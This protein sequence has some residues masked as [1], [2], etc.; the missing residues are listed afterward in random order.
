MQTQIAPIE[1][2]LVDNNGVIIG[3]SEKMLV[4]RRGLLHLAFSLMIT[5]QGH[6]GTEF[7]LQRR[8][9]HKYHSGGLWTNTCCSHPLKHE[10][11]ADAAKRRVNDELGVTAPLDIR[12]VAK[13][14]YNHQLENGLYEN[15]YNHLLLADVEDIK[16]NGNP[17]EVM[18]IRWWCGNEI[19][20]ALLSSPERF[21]AWFSE[22][23]ANVYHQDIS[24]LS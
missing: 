10:S 11:I 13:I 6:K 4:H 2:P 14:Q 12:N 22:V 16:W 8:A 3:Y 18:D 5:R 19:Q 21:T 9:S 15:E 7:L 24:G 1:V 17:D 20:A 23:F